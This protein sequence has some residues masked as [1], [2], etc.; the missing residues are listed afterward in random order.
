[1]TDFILRVETAVT[2]RGIRHSITSQVEPVFTGD[3]HE[4][5]KHTLDNHRAAIEALYGV[6]E[7]LI[8]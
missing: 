7:V 8:P 1:M 3:E 5:F 6:E 4:A 2:F